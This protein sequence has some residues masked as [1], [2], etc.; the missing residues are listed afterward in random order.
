M[1]ASCTL[2]RHKGLFSWSSERASPRPSHQYPGPVAGVRI[3]TTDNQ[4]LLYE[5]HSPAIQHLKALHLSWYKT[6]L[7]LQYYKHWFPVERPLLT[8]LHLGTQSLDSGPCRCYQVPIFPRNEE[9][10]ALVIRQSL[11]SPGVLVQSP[12]LPDPSILRPS[13]LS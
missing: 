5:N 7:Q 4:G 2:R 6:L 8:T 9:R 3:S 11:T 13:D 12:S 10:I 1:S